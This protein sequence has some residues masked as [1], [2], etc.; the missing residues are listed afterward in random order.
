MGWWLVD[1]DTLA[2]SRFVR[3]PL[4][5]TLAGLIMLHKHAVRLPGEREFLRAHSAAYRQRLAADPVDA[6]LVDAVLR[7][8]WIANFASPAPPPVESSFEAEV[9]AVRA[10]PPAVVL[11]DL[12]D[13]LA[14]SGSAV[15]HAAGPSGPC[16]S[17]PRPSGRHS[18]R[19][20]V[21]GLS[22][23]SDL[24]GMPDLGPRMADLLTWVWR[25]TVE[26][27]W[28]RRGRVVEADILARTRQLSLGGWAAALDRMR[29]GMRW[30]GEGRLQINAFD[31]PP[32]DISGTQL[33]LVPV[34]MTRGWV[35]QEDGRHAV[36]YRCS[37][38]LADTGAVAAGALERL[39][40]AGRA[41]VL[42]ELDP[43]KSTTQ[44]VAVTGLG[45]GS[46]G[47]HLKVLLEAGLVL[48]R[49]AG[50][51]VLYARTAAGNAVVEASLLR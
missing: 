40:G 33:V 10:T 49:R 28:A 7:P 45:L 18:S 25:H 50:R 41:R 6:R 12:A 37:G 3:S 46:V 11:A 5:E 16:P 14:F 13:G 1:A 38:L 2:G 27:D 51:N 23:L 4:A 44:L 29:E 47:R 9:A 21:S 35:A 48:R 20:S 19:G 34:T 15:P 36:V 39:L 8:R 43:P 26:P 22:L 32:R 42:V 31:H 17:G 30:L 24:S